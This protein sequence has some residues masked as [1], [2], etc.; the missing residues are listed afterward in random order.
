MP[1]TISSFHPF[2]QLP[3][4][5]RLAI[6]EI[7]LEDEAAKRVTVCFG[8]R[9]IANSVYLL[10]T[11]QYCSSILSASKESRICALEWYNVKV[12]VI[13][14][15]AP[16]RRG[17]AYLRMD[18]ELIVLCEYIPWTRNRYIGRLSQEDTAKARIVLRV[19]ELHHKTKRPYGPNRDNIALFPS[20]ECLIL[21]LQPT[22]RVLEAFIADVDQM[23]RD[24]ALLAR[25]EYFMI[26]DPQEDSTR[27]YTRAVEEIGD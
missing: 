21:M 16:D 27:G 7:V 4:E 9:T 14:N 3:I 11:S 26:L 6:W 19:A 2:P 23:G 20:L 13:C 12:E 5:L 17:I 25:Q 18:R 24:N 10:P 15:E 8:R 22:C 1:S